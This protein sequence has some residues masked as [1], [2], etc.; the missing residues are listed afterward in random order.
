MEEKQIIEKNEHEQDIKNDNFFIAFFLGLIGI[1][2]GA[3]LYGLLSYFNRIALITS[4][5]SIFLSLSF[6]AMYRNRNANK[7]LIFIYAL[8]SI[9]AILLTDAIIW[10]NL[11]KE[12]MELYQ[13]SFIQ[14]VSLYPLYI[15]DFGFEIY[16]YFNF[17]IVF[18]AAFLFAFTK[19]DFTSNDEKIEEKIEED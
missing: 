6:Y 8:I 1:I 3:V 19:T 14:L 10:A 2:I 12:A 13:I 4:A 5:A 9:G 18:G 7:F 17:L 15:K 16:D 11:N